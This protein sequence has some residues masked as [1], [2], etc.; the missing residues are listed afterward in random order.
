MSASQQVPRS[1]SAR[2][3]SQSDIVVKPYNYNFSQPPREKKLVSLSVFDLFGLITSGKSRGATGFNY[4]MP[5]KLT[6][7]LT[8]SKPAQLAGVS[9]ALALWAL[10]PVGKESRYFW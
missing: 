4:F 7:G 6:Q 8:G 2:F 5:F 10:G 9:R 3:S 1:D